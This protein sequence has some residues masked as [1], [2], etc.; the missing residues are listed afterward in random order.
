MIQDNAS[1]DTIEKMKENFEKSL[2]KFSKAEPKYVEEIL[3]NSIYPQIQQQIIKN[4]DR[5]FDKENE[6][7]YPKEEKPS[8]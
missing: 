6:E 5:E 8:K 7:M 3:T 4:I 2:E 1:V